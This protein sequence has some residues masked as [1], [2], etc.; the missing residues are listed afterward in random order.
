MMLQAVLE[1]TVTVGQLTLVGTELMNLLR[2]SV[3]IAHT[4]QYV[5]QLYTVSTNVLYRRS[6][7]AAGNQRQIFQSHQVILQTEFNQRMPV[8]ARCCCHQ[9]MHGRQRV[10]THNNAG[11][12]HLNH[13]PRKICG[14]QHIAAAPQN[15]Y[16][17][18]LVI[19]LLQQGRQFIFL[20]Q[21]G[22]KPCACRD[23]KACE[24]RQINMT[25]P[26]ARPGAHGNSL[27]V[28][29]RRTASRSSGVSTPAGTRCTASSMMMRTP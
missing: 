9:N 5:R 12:C 25:Q 27:S 6:A 24:A 29:N 16:R 26:T 22:K 8:L 1:D 14:Q 17:Q 21:T 3:K 11:Q 28:K 4:H 23:T 10:R 20:L 13:Q 18:V 15:Q 19:G 7:G 2:A